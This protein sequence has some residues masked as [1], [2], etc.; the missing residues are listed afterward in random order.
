[1][2][3]PQGGKKVFGTDNTRLM[4]GGEVKLPS[5][6]TINVT[7]PPL[8]A[9]KDRGICMGMC[10]RWVLK[11]YQ[12]ED[13]TQYD[14]AK[15]KKNDYLKSAQAQA[16][17]EHAC[18]RVGGNEEQ[19]RQLCGFYGLTVIGSTVTNEYFRD[20]WSDYHWR[21]MKKSSAPIPPQG[22]YFIGGTN[23]HALAFR[24]GAD[25]SKNY[26]F[27]PNNGLYEYDDRDTMLKAIHSH[28]VESYGW[29]IGYS[30]T[31]VALQ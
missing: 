17:Y 27:D 28:C 11:S 13:V 16:V 9:E 1:M 26:Y 15:L 24:I 7:V 25:P 4:E 23:L 22:Y 14:D 20:A 5:K 21:Y 10:V 12:L 6:K 18:S 30:I 2:G 19:I 3:E 8:D 29:H 31:R